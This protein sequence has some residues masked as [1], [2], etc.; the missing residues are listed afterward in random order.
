MRTIAHLGAP[1]TFSGLAARQWGGTH[2]YYKSAGSFPDLFQLL[3]SDEADLVLVPVENSLAGAVDENLDLLGSEEYWI[4]AET[5]LSVDLC[6]GAYRKIEIGKLTHV[7]S[8]PK[9]LEQCG[10]FLG[11]YP[12][13]IKVPTKDTASAAAYVASEDNPTCAVIASPAA[14]K[15]YGLCVLQE[16]LADLH[17]NT[18]R[19][20]VMSRELARHAKG[21]KATIV[22][23][24][25]HRPGALVKVLTRL[26][27]LNFNLTSIESRPMKTT[28]FEYRFYLD[29]TLPETDWDSWLEKLSEV[30]QTTRTL[31]LLGIYE[32]Q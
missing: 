31:K 9:A 18:T 26:A 24:L 12:D 3:E 27:E 17:P 20:F 8:H 19:F 30:S 13:V 5:T 15:D 2:Y 21:N 23:T 25:E 32:A 22:M 6:L 16:K 4:V 29:L 28:P 10:D 7:L 14:M 11:R 1:S